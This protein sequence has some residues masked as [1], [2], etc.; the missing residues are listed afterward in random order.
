M[1]L[2]RRHGRFGLFWRRQRC[3]NFSLF[4]IGKAVPS[5]AAAGHVEE[6]DSG[7]WSSAQSKAVACKSEQPLLTFQPNTPTSS[8]Q[9][10]VWPKE[11][12]SKAINQAQYLSPMS[13]F[14]DKKILSWKTHC[15]A[16]RFKLAGLQAYAGARWSSEQMRTCCRD[17]APVK[18]MR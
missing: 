2:R 7:A 14:G 10:D 9:A 13:H 16:K 11:G 5:F 12:S 18:G 4:R 3:A 1:W 15:H 6:A 17:A 8:L